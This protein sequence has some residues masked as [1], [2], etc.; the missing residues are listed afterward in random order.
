MKICNRCKRELPEEKFS[1]D[2]SKKDGLRTI[3]K[4][5]THAKQKQYRSENKEKIAL[6]KRNTLKKTKKKFLNI[7]RNIT[8]KTKKKFLKGKKKY[9]EENK[10]KIS[11]R[12]KEYR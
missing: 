2:A 9:N 12:Q 11:E 7:K 8:K 5:C 1:K 3:C 4:D 10:E 6:A